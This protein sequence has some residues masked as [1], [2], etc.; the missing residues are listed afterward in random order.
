[1]LSPFQF[2]SKELV[3]SEILENSFKNCPYL[4]KALIEK[5]KIS[6]LSTSNNL[7]E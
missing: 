2:R 7:I 1:M 4:F 6:H 3:V 5:K